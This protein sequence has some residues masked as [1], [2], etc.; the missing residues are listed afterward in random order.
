MVDDRAIYRMDQD[1]SGAGLV[2]VPTLAGALQTQAGDSHVVA[3]NLEH[4]PARRV[5]HV[6]EVLG[7]SGMSDRRVFAADAVDPGYPARTKPEVG[8]TSTP[9]IWLKSQNS[10]SARL[11]VATTS[12]DPLAPRAFCTCTTSVWS[13]ARMMLSP[14]S[15]NV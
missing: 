1:A 15:A 2:F 8:S 3:D 10:E 13:P 12:G 7:D 9:A 11:R 6:Q 4:R 5:P 14:S